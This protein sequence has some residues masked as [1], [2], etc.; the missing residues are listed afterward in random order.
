[1]TIEARAAP[2]AAPAVPELPGRAAYLPVALVAGSVIALQIAIMRL[3]AVGNW[4]HFGSMVVSLAMFGFGLASAVMCVRTPAF[5]RHW[6]LAASASLVSIGPL[7]VA[8]NAAAQNLSFNAIFLISDPAQKWRLAANFILYFLPFLAAAFFLGVVFLKSRVNFA[9]VYF[10]DLTGSGLCGF[11]MLGALYLFPP[12]SIIVVP[13]ILW[14]LGGLLWFLFQ[15]SRLGAL[16][17]IA[18]AAL[19]L[20]APVVL[21]TLGVSTLSISDYKGVSY[22]RKFP[23]AT[24]VHRDLSP[25]GELEIYRSSYF[26][27]APG[28]S[29]NAAFE[30]PEIPAN[31]YLGLYNDGDGPSGLIRHLAEADTA[32][33]RFLPMYYPYVLKQAPATFIVQLSGGISTALAL[34]SGAQS[35]TVA[36]A[37]P[38]VRAA[39]GAP[40]IREFTGDVLADPRVTVIG[41]EGRIHLAHT[42]ARYDVVDL[43]LADSVGLSSPGGFAVVERFAYTREA[44]RTYMSA[45]KDGGILAVTLWN[46]EDPP[47]SVLKLYATMVEAARQIA[48]ESIARAFYASSS[49]LSTTTVLYKRGGFSD[50]EIATLRKYTRSLSF[51][52]VYYPGLAVDD[53]QAEATLAAY[54]AQIFGSGEDAPADAVD[55]GDGLGPSDDGLSGE[56]SSDAPEVVPSTFLGRIAW[57]ALIHGGWEDFAQRYVFDTRP[58]SNDRPYFAAYVKPGDLPRITDRLELFQD[59]WGYLLIWATLGIAC[60]MG[61]VLVVL[62]ALLGWRG[63]ASGAPAALG[64]IVYFAGL[65]AGYIM[66]EVGL[67]SKFVLALS[68]ATVSASILLSGI[69]VFSGLG[70][71]ASERLIARARRA[72]P[73]VLLAIVALLVVY[74]LFADDVLGAIA[75]LP[76]G[77]R[78]VLCLALVAPPAFAMGFPMPIA[79]TTL[80]RLGRERLFIWAWGINGCASVI[81]ASAV[82]IVATAFGSSA[83]LQLSAIAYLLA[84]PAFIGVLWTR[85]GMRSQT[86]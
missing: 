58:L 73:L 72:V 59:D 16:L 26:H 2:A 51:D 79:M 65:G 60:A 53:A 69:L 17:F 70:S 25:F 12:A 47:K 50:A 7:A 74:S 57:H 35:V 20:A 5:E 84:I 71:V 62:P 37:N 18:V 32:Y 41:Q 49:Y 6:R 85:R 27:I 82:P 30:L 28:L 80:G 67:I 75:A 45:L 3:F 66:T 55:A 8:G 36:E 77:W 44:M 11:A 22:A 78:L 76:Y 86:A 81:G 15:R 19:S 42:D 46:K 31:A 54:D 56:V 43:S 29:D 21:P 1:M 4:V 13:L 10:A 14:A 63:L 68:N 23:D 24:V 39:F 48:P 64:T 83:V 9:R 61:L 34:R 52:D 38:A 33:F 40:A